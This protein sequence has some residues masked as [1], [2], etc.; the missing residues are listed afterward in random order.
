[1]ENPEV[2][3]RVLREIRIYGSMGGSKTIQSSATNLHELQ[4]DLD[5]FG[6]SYANMHHMVG[7]TRS[8]LLEDK[9]SLPEGV[10]TLFLTPIKTK[11]GMDIASMGYKE[12]RAE[13]KRVIDI[14]GDLAKEHF[15][16]GKNYTTKPT[17]TLR[18]LLIS[19]QG[20]SSIKYVKESKEAYI[21]EV[22]KPAEKVKKEKVVEVEVQKPDGFTALLARI[23]TL[24]KRVSVLENKDCEPQVVE[25]V[26][27]PKTQFDD[28][29]SSAE[30]EQEARRH[31][32]ELAAKIK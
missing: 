28:S 6:I 12:L 21:P 15:N 30:W 19:W 18:E 26:K 14:T 23:E 2:K 11:S 9:S 10:F 31:A 4:Q 5:E 24:E 7:E 1:M 20:K 3:V 25:V 16:E 13:V 8:L 27:K 29:K 17:E 32:A 22:E